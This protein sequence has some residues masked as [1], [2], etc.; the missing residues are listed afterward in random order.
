[1][2]TG[3][4]VR[5][6][7]W[8]VLLSTIAFTLLAVGNTYLFRTALTN[9]LDDELKA[10]TEQVAPLVYIV[11]NDL[12]ARGLMEQL[13]KSPYGLKTT[14]QLFDAHSELDEEHGQKGNAR[15]FLTTTE[16]PGPSGNLRSK[17]VPLFQDG[18][19]FGYL[20][21][22]I[23]TAQRDLAVDKFVF[24]KL[25][26]GP[27][28]LFGL[29]LAGFM[30]SGKAVKPVE[31]AYQMLKM[32]VQD[33]G[34]ELKTP[35]ATI[36]I[37]AENL[38][39][40]IKDDPEKSESLAIIIRNTDRMSRLV[41]DMLTL[42][43]MEVA[44]SNVKLSHISLQPLIERARE[45]FSPRFETQDK[46][47]EIQIDNDSNILGDSESLYHLFS[48]L[49]E[50]ALKYSEKGASVKV[51]VLNKNGLITVAVQDTGM[52]IPKEAVPRLFDRFYRVDR[53]AAR[54]KGGT[55]L[56]LSIVKAIADMHD[57]VIDVASTEGKGTTFTVTFPPA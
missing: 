1:M 22:Q 4:R 13:H 16:V 44:R 49:I 46:K 25:M 2:F 34:H 39:E 56:G 8:F 28:F 33:A 7:L 43:K 53:Q 24:T 9:A 41:T 27:V 51:S 35:V 26:L 48:N 30:V 29:A 20:Q 38:A 23:P 32:F 47:L 52:G 42:A 36:Q 6:T 55:G 19:L 18:H 17:S 11:R 45:E 12:Q 31:E 40:D 57:A 21:V 37:T 14:V 50:N 3:L 54:A 5:L 15:L 10:L